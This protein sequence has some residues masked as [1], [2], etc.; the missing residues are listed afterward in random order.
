MTNFVRAQKGGC[1]EYVAMEPLSH[2]QGMCSLYVQKHYHHCGVPFASKLT[3]RTGAP[4]SEGMD[5][6]LWKDFRKNL[7]RLGSTPEE[8]QRTIKESL[9]N[10]VPEAKTVKARIQT[11]SAQIQSGR[12][13]YICEV[14]GERFESARRRSGPKVC[15][16]CIGYLRARGQGPV[17]MKEEANV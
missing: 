16:Q 7:D 13:S 10:P 6:V 11:L 5:P 3:C 8:R 2:Y 9:R 15:A 17:Q 12:V 14:C 4:G 1:H